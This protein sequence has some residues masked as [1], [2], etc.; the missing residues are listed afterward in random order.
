MFSDVPPCHGTPAEMSGTSGEFWI[1]RSQYR[2]NMH[3][4]WVVTVEDGKVS[5]VCLVVSI[6]I[7]SYVTPDAVNYYIK[8][9]G[10]LHVLYHASLAST[11]NTMVILTAGAPPL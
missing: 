5:F 10:H 2:K 6:S 7:T 3:C 8:E 9:I 1:S 4:Q 11:V